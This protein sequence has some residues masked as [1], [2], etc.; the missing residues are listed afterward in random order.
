M[1]NTKS[2]V[3][4][5]AEFDLDGNI[6]PISFIWE[7]GR[8]YELDRVITS[9]RS[10]SLKSGGLGIRYTCRVRNR[11]VYLYLEEDRFWFMETP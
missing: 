2:F 11:I 10:A 4:V 6:T 8:E 5:K 1:N 9:C 3:K 7:N